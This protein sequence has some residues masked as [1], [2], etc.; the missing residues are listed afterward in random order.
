MN[1]KTY[2]VIGL[3]AYNMQRHA[4]AVGAEDPRHAEET[5]LGLMA[6]SGAG[7]GNGYEMIVAGVVEGNVQVLA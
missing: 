1:T 6:E 2:T 3:Y 7:E 5:Y 4:M